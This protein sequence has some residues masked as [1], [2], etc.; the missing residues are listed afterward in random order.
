MQGP[1]PSYAVFVPKSGNVLIIRR[2]P[3]QWVHAISWNPETDVVS[4]GGWLKAQVDSRRC[5]VSH[6]GE[7]WIFSSFRRARWRCQEAADAITCLAR[8][9]WFTALVLWESPLRYL[10]GGGR[11]L[12]TRTMQ[13]FG[14][15]SETMDPIPRDLRIVDGDP[16][17]WR[18]DTEWTRSWEGVDTEGRRARIADNRLQVK[19][20][21]GDWFVIHDLSSEL[22]PAPRP[23]P[24][25]ASCWPE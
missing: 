12:G 21:A 15:Y 9:P 1:T 23:S 3:T 5:D 24:D 2:G 4:P 7:L 25:W 11:F 20:A 17:D 8:P 16:K 10:R 22:K 14:S 19:R 13:L 6:D 18:N